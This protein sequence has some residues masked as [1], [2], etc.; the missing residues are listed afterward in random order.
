MKELKI[1]L[2]LNPQYMP[3]YISIADTYM[4]LGARTNKEGDY[5]KA[6]NWF[7]KAYEINP[8]DLRLAYA[9]GT[10]FYYRRENDKAI[11]KL[12]YAYAHGLD[13]DPLK[14][15]LAMAYNNKAY[16]LYQ[17]GANLD[18]GMSLIDKAIELMPNNGIIL[19][20]K[21]EL[22][23][24]MGKYAEAQKYIKMALDLEPNHEEMKQDF[25]MIEAAL[26]IGK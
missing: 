1:A 12:E 9:M 13:G 5:Q 8:K 18:Q 22:L 3:T 16:S 25:K 2:K 23:Y 17:S 26:K 14:E 4:L 15:D 24:K 19:G 11:E 6:L 10:F 7:N 21:A 20:T